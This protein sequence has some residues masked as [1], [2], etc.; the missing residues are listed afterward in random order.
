LLKADVKIRRLLQSDAEALW[1][2]RLTALE[3]EPGAFAE[4]AEEH[5]STST[6]SYAE[7]LRAAQD[8]FVL[9]AVAAGQLIGM[10]GFY[11]EQR[12]KRRHK[13]GIWGMFVLPEYRGAGVARALL[14]A[15]L[16]QV[17]SLGDIRYVQLS[18]TSSQPAARALYVSLGFRPVGVEPEALRTAAGGF[19]DEEH[20]SL[21][22]E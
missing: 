6:E 14:T 15:A 16:D 17:R 13:G 12:L 9:G 22:L 19:V 1:R 21:R 18:V 7:R 2:L 8:N 20:M 11:R 10:V 4:S 5:R 3:S